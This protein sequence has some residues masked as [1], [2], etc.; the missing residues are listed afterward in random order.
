[1]T[2]DEILA[3]LRRYRLA[4]QSSV[5]PDGAPQSAV[6]GFAVSDALEI[7]FDTLESSRKARNLRADPR[8][9]LVIGWDHEITAQIEGIADFPTGDERDRIRDVY[10]ASWPDGRDRLAWPGI[11]HVRA[12]PNWIRYSDFTVDPARIAEIDLADRLGPR[13]PTVIPRIFVADVP[14]LVAYARDVL[15][16]TGDLR[17]DVP[18]VLTIGDSRVMISGT[19]VRGVVPAFLYVY[20]P[21]AD[22]AWRR[23]VA[24]GA[25]TIEPPL[26]TPYGDRRATVRDPWGNTWQIATRQP[27][28]GVVGAT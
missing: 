17:Q 26:D 5:G 28:S 22:E 4:V 6:V 8:V 1:M 25:E 20:V 23:A 16:A 10:F 21:D 24:R 12:R 3:F 11:T 15:G 14:A 7:V 2:R 18:T 9:S 19:E 13:W 27:P